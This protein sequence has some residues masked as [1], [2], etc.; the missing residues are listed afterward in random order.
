MADVTIG[1]NFDGVL[2]L[3]AKS[4]KTNGRTNLNQCSCL[5]FPCR[6]SQ[7]NPKQERESFQRSPGICLI[8]KCPCP[9]HTATALSA[10]NSFT[11]ME[12]VAI[13]HGSSR[14]CVNSKQVFGVSAAD[15]YFRKA[16]TVMG[17]IAGTFKLL[18]TTSS[19]TPIVSNLLLATQRKACS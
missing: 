8:L 7:R 6:V 3:F 12:R 4:S 14:K 11:L 1:K 5:L 15:P 9:L 17:W 18:L 16:D 13:H 2:C 10:E 19:S